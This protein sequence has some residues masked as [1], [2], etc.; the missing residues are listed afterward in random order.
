MAKILV[1]DDEKDICEEFRD[2]LEEENHLVDIACRAEEALKRIRENPYDLVFLDILMPH[3]E[4][5]RV[6]QEI[7]KIR[8]V[9]VAIMSGFLPPAKEKEIMALGALTCLSKP[10]DL[11]DVKKLLDSLELRKAS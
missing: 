11:R 7:K 10:L 3:M 2:I 5:S 4:G 6:L 1:V 9:P 8:Q